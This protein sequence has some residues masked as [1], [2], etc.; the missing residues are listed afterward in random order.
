M[1]EPIQKQES[2]QEIVEHIEPSSAIDTVLK[3]TE[4]RGIKDRA[5]VAVRSKL[6]K[7]KSEEEAIVIIAAGRELG[8]AP[9]TSLRLIHMIEGKVGLETQVM[10]AIVMR[11]VPGARIDFIERTEKK[12][13]VEVEKPGHSPARFDFT[14]EE[15]EF[16]GLT[17]KPN[18]KYRKAMLSNRARAAACRE[19]FPEACAGIYDPEELE[20]LAYDASEVAKELESLRADL[21]SMMPICP[22]EPELRAAVLAEARVSR[23]PARLRFLIDR[24]QTRIQDAAIASAIEAAKQEGSHPSTESPPHEPGEAVDTKAETTIKKAK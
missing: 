2:S 19:Y 14:I 1:I 7:W 23:D 12:C 8:L 9:M 24:A 22:A 5:R 17:R 15:A 6:T 4:W 16:A 3:E 10:H 21:E 11:R 18:W 20:G 13:I